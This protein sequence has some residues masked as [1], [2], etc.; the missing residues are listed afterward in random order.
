MY[1]Q[2]SRLTKCRNGTCQFRN[3]HTNIIDIQVLGLM[4]SWKHPPT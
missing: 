2:F 3:V 1:I 4:L